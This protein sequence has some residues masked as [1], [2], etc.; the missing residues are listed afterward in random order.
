MK[1]VKFYDNVVDFYIP[2][3]TYIPVLDAAKLTIESIMRDYPPPYHLMVSGGIDS[4]AMLYMWSKFG[5]DFIPT[6]VIYNH[7]YNLHDILDVTNL[8]QNYNFSVKYIDF[9]LLTFLKDEVKDYTHR[10]QCSSPCISTHIKMSEDL[11]G[12][13]I[14]SGDFLTNGKPI[15]SNAILG[16]YR[17]SLERKNIIPYFF[18]HT[19]EL[20]YSLQP[21]QLTIDEMGDRA[22]DPKIMT[23]IKNGIPVLR[24]KIKATGFEKI[25]DYYD[26]HYYHL[27]PPI[28][29]IKFATK[30]SKRTFDLLLR[31]PYEGMYDKVNL[32]FITN[33]FG[34][35]LN[36]G[37]TNY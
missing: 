29:R 21:T 9:D 32:K 19:P 5:K 27:V 26:E 35:I 36:F 17:A 3:L 34:E 14:Y 28:N 23:Y 10:Y 22:Y 2:E 16:L 15:L 7:N 18:L 25:K 20:A 12:T 31:Y 6:S 24:Q 13:V 1:W 8:N 33:K 4:Q 30:P 37:Q 11:P